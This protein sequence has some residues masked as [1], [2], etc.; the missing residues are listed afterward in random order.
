MG[1]EV[2]YLDTGTASTTDYFLRGLAGTEY[3]VTD[4]FGIFGEI[5]IG[6]IPDP[7]VMFPGYQTGFNYYY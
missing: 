5:V 2:E 3:K 1:I 7:L 4:T 6:I